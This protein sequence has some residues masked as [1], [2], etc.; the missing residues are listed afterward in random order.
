MQSKRRILALIFLSLTGIAS[1]LWAQAGQKTPAKMVNLAGP[2]K[3]SYHIHGS[4]TTRAASAWEL[5]TRV[6]FTQLAKN[7]SIRIISS[8]TADSPRVTIYGILA[9]DSSIDKN[10]LRVSGTDSVFGTK[11]FKYIS[12]AAVDTEAAGTISIIGKTS[13]LVTTIRPGFLETEVAHFYSGRTPAVLTGWSVEIDTLSSAWAELRYYPDFADSRETPETGKRVLDGPIFL[14]A[15]AGTNTR[16]VKEFMP[17]ARW[18]IGTAGYLAIFV[19]SGAT[20]AR[21]ENAIID[22]YQK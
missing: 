5:V 1:L 12:Y 16:Y 13:G 6:P 8:S 22:I 15:A 2:G 3:D 9:R 19:Q 11:Q 18:E 20:A 14:K 21:V 10:I 7:D 4:D 17:D